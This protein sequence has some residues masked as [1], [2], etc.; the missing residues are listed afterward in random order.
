MT[1]KIEKR[2][3]FRNRETHFLSC[4]LVFDPLKLH[5]RV[6]LYTYRSVAYQKPK[7]K[8]ILFA[9]AISSA[10]MLLW[11]IAVFPSKTNCVYYCCE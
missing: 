10:K 1:N 2:E 8:C 3:Q 7:T 9:V 11:I 4:S 6:K 5:V